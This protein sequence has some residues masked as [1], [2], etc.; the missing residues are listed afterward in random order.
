MFILNGPAP[1]LKFR[2]IQDEEEYVEMKLNEFQWPKG[3]IG[4]CPICGGKVVGKG[5]DW[6][7]EN[8]ECGMKF[9]GPIF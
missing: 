5:K 4:V 1:I 8:E 7:C 6:T 9:F 3:G 2:K